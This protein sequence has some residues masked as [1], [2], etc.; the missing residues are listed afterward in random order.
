MGDAVFNRKQKSR[1]KTLSADKAVATAL[2]YTVCERVRRFV[3]AV[4]FLIAVGNRDTHSSL[5]NFF[6]LLSSHKKLNKTI[7]NGRFKKLQPQPQNNIY[8]RFK[9]FVADIQRKMN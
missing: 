9:N 7:N 5:H 4:F 6:I 8:T 3:I 2:L 1:L